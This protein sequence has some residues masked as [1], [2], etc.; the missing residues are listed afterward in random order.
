MTPVLE[1]WEKQ[2]FKV[3][4]DSSV[5][6]L[7]NMDRWISQVN[8]CDAILSVA[9]TTIHGSGGLGKPTLCLLSQKSDWRWLSTDEVE[10]S[11]WYGSVGIARQDINENWDKA[12]KEAVD[13]INRG[14]IPYDGPQWV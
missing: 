9:N 8:A 1:R 12:M 5:D 14:C 13:W 2:G 11:Y 4:N 7:K 10:R 3:I 6:S